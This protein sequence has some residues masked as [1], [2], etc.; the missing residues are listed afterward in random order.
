MFVNT[1]PIYADV[2]SIFYHSLQ[3][4]CGRNNTKMARANYDICTVLRYCCFHCYLY[5]YIF[6]YTSCFIQCFSTQHR[7]PPTAQSRVQD[8]FSIWPP[9]SPFGLRLGD[10]ICLRRWKS[11]CIPNFDQIS[12]STA[13]I[14][15]GVEKRTAAILEFYFRFQKSIW[16]FVQIET[17]F[18]WRVISPTSTWLP[19]SRK[20]TFGLRF[21]DGIC[22]RR[23]KSTCVPNF[24][25]ISQST[26]EI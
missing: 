23:W 6:S 25:E 9:W 16:R 13:D 21:S 2:F 5:K 19:R 7:P 1:G 15:S 20:S 12:Q 24:D 18:G 26:A 8:V 3:L 14:T 10:G 17:K 4:S 22:L 11:I